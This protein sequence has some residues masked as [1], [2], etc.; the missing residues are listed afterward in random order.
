MRVAIVTDSN[1]GITQEQGRQ[2]GIY[3]V[4]MPFMMAGETY[5]EDIS[6]TQKSFYERLAEGA[7]ISTSQPSPASLIDLWNEL[8]KDHDSVI[9]I[10]M[11]SGLSSSARRPT[12]WP[13]TLA[14]R[15]WWST[16]REFL[17]HSGSP[18]S[19]RRPWRIRE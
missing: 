8:L 11:S 16:T 7:D 12:R 13:P 17:L 14:E 4:P 3:V 2:A 19:R 15:C 18:F 9:H 1:S 6:L 10:P 5:F